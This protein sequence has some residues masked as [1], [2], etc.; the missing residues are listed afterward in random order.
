MQITF[1]EL[2]I[3]DRFSKWD[4][5]VN[6]PHYEKRNGGNDLNM[7]DLYNGNLGYMHP[8]RIVYIPDPEDEVF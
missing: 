6:I 1:G 8:S 2:K 5:F 4:K 3:G 7:I